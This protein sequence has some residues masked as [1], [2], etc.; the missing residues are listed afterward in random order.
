MHTNTRASFGLVRGILL[1][2]VG[3]LWAGRGAAADTNT[4]A[5]T[6]SEGRAAEA[7]VIGTQESLRSSL[8]IQEE[9]HNMQA[10]IEKDRKDSEAAAAR[11]ADLLE[12][13]LK[14]IEQSI[15]SQRL[16]ELKDLQRSNRTVLLAAGAFAVVGFVVLL[17]AAFVQWTAV[18]RITALSARLP[19]A[20]GMGSG[21]AALGMGD[22]ALLPGQAEESTARFLGV[23]AKLERRIDGIEKAAPPAQSL[24]GKTE[25]NH[26][27]ANGVNGGPVQEAAG[28]EAPGGLQ[29]AS[30]IALLLGKGQTLLKL[31][32]PEAAIACFDEALAIDA[33]NTDILVRKGAALE[34]LQRLDE[35]IA[36]YDMAIAADSTMTMAYLY[37]GGVYN[38][39][40]RYSEALECYEQALKT[41]QKGQSANVVIES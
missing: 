38:R 29:Q 36:C 28:E 14:L 12:G 21:P 30:A 4:N 19:A 16:D 22:A 27:S 24:P 20:M 6:D 15:S 25:G 39:L 18:S 7:V 33:G 35:A 31:D 3:L 23:I 37:K 9:L 5:P 41:Q 10:T 13:R 17:F 2:C 34:R 8:Q 40:E 32:K 26:E 1:I 11:S